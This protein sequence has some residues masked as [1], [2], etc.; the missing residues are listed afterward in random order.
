MID[1]L[2]PSEIVEQARQSYQAGDYLQAARSFAGA[3]A[4]FA[5][6]G[7]ALMAAEMQN[8]RSVALLLGG[9]P[10]AALQAVVATDKVFAEAQ[11]FRRMGMALTN[12]ASALEALKR[13]KEA[14]DYY[15]RAAEALEQAK[16]SD[17][18][19]Q[20]MQ[21]LAVLYLRRFKFYD[22]VITLQSS[23]AG[24]TNPTFK[25]RLM[26]KILFVHL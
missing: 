7:D 26:K 20:V 5:F 17:M 15:K 16:E 13:W 19:A 2:S 11:D 10:Q 6:A 1:I 12:Q 8:N 9:D 23:L 21:L 3:G 25:Q 18:R 24:V 22:A 4:A 14:I